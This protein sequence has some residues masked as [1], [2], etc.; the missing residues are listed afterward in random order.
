[1]WLGQVSFPL[2]LIHGP[3]LRSVLIWMVFGARKLVWVPDR[4]TAGEQ[5]R[6]VTVLP[7]PKAWVVI[8]SV[9]VFFV[10]LGAASQ[11]WNVYVEP[12]CAKVTRWVED[13]MCPRLSEGVGKVESLEKGLPSANGKGGSPLLD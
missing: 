12:R 10:I 13:V 4:G 6:E 9:P 11:C 2:Y 8:L 3:L 1:M 5:T 7:M